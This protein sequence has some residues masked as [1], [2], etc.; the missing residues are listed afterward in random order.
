MLLNANLSYQQNKKPPELLQMVLIYFKKLIIDL[1]AL[2][3]N[4]LLKK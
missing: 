3:K 1:E 2:Y 4:V